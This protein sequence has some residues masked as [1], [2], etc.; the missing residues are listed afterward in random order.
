MT[1]TTGTPTKLMI[2]RVNHTRMLTS[3][4]QCAIRIR[5]CRICITRTG[6]ANRRSSR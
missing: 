4:A 6:T 3:T 2:R 1:S 5:T